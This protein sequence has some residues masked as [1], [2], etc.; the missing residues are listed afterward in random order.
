MKD[1]SQITPGEK[2]GILHVNQQILPALNVRVKLRPVE[3]ED[4]DV[5][6]DDGD[7]EE[8]VPDRE[9]MK[10]QTL[11]LINARLKNN[12][13]KKIKKKKSAKD[14]EDSS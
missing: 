4:A 3:F 8:E 5:E 9:S 14:G 2:T 13:P 10:K 12:Q 1:P 7:E 11:H 6:D